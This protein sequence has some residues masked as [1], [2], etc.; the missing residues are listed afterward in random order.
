MGKPREGA[1]GMTVALWK[2]T[3]GLQRRLSCT[4]SGREE[5]ARLDFSG[6]SAYRTG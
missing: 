1:G 4:L 2:I 5:F 3:G 6:S